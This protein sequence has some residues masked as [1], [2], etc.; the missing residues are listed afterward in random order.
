MLRVPTVPLNRVKLGLP[1]SLYRPTLMTFSYRTQHI[2]SIIQDIAVPADSEWVVK[3]TPYTRLNE[4]A[5]NRLMTSIL[6]T[7]VQSMCLHNS[8]IPEPCESRMRSNEAV[9]AP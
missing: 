3:S 4:R 8:T 5:I 9:R 6:S 2:F 1:V 7:I